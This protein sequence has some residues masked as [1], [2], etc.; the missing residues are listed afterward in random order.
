MNVKR[1]AS[2]GATLCQQR[3]VWGEPWRRSSG[4]PEPPLYAAS[5]RP[6][7]V[8][9]VSAVKPSNMRRPPAPS[10]AILNELEPTLMK[11]VRFG[12]K[13]SEKPGL[14]VSVGKIRDLSAHVADITGETLAPASLAKLKGID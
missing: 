12:A 2:R 11:L 14:V 4:G 1:E 13:G 5:S 3:C 6:L 8:S 9:I 10:I 7:P